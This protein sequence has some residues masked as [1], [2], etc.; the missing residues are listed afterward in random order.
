MSD[1]CPN[2]GHPLDDFFKDKIKAEL[3]DEFKREKEEQFLDL[4]KKIEKKDLLIR[5][6]ENDS[7]NNKDL[8]R[9][10]IEQELSEDNKQK[11]MELKKE[12]IELQG[13][14]NTLK[15]HK[16]KEISLA[17]GQALQEQE[18]KLDA[19]KKLET[20]EKDNEIASLKKFIKELEEKSNQKSQQAK[21]EVGEILIE[22]TLKIE[23]PI[24]NIVEVPKGQNG[25]DISHYV[26]DTSE[27]DLG[28]IYI[29]SKYA[30]KFSSNW[31]KK[32]KDDMKNKKADFG[33]LVTLDIPEN[34]KQYEEDDLFI[35]G[36]HDYYLAVKFLRGRIIALAR[37][38]TLEAN[39]SSERLIYDYVTGREFAQWMRGL[40]DFLNEQQLQLETDKSQAIKSFGTRQAQLDKIK[41]SHMDLAGQFKGLG[42]VNDFNM[43]DDATSPN[44]IENDN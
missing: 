40:I 21:G 36:F 6:L 44:L 42:S 4:S 33:V 8:L 31:I 39:R 34:F 24:D 12:K 2:C 19:E 18:T 35:C 29:E 13:E 30:K 17:V 15:K 27:N 16:E 3:K 37:Q 9:A 5:K 11:E 26:R 38:N 28:L 32:L 41:K 10:Q 43:L 7:K 23:F 20:T 22:K 14:I 25:A 1:N